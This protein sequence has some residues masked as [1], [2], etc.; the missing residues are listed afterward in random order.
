[1]RGMYFVGLPAAATFG[2]VMRFVCGAPF[3][4]HRVAAAAAPAG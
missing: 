3:A 4:A 2:P 1:M